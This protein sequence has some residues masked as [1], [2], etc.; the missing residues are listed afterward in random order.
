MNTASVT[1][2]PTSAAARAISRASSISDIGPCEARVMG[3]DRSRAA[4]RR[5]AEGGE[6]AEIGIDRRHRAEAQQP[7]LE[8]LAG[9]AERGRREGPRMVVRIDERGHGEQ[10]TGAEPSAQA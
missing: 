10:A 4:A 5:A 9:A 2:T 8:R 3:H 7:G 1:R 6:R